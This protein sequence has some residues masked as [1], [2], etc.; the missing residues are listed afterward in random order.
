M[1]SPW[2]ISCDAS[3]SNNG[4]QRNAIEQIKKD[5]SSFY[6]RI[7]RRICSPTA[8]RNRFARR[9]NR[10]NSA[11]IRLISNRRNGRVNGPLVTTNHLLLP[12]QR[13]KAAF[14]LPISQPNS[15]FSAVSAMG[16]LRGAGGVSQTQVAKFRLSISSHRKFI[17]KGPLFSLCHS[18]KPPRYTVSE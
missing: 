2:L 8:G 17:T 12:S 10:S 16:E 13:G 3:L 5:R 9:K 7:L 6:R 11:D 4:A 15:D 14:S 18:K 1:I